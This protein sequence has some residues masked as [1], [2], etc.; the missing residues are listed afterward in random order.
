MKINPYIFR[1]YDLRGEIN[2]DLNPKIAEH[3]GR[4]FG[5]MLKRQGIKKA[6]IGRDSR[7]TSLEYSESIIK[8]L[9]FVGINTIDIGMELIGTFYW[10]QYFLNCQGGVFVSASHN[11]AQYNGFK[12][13]NGFSETLISKEMKIL[14]QMAEND[15]FEKSLILGK[16]EKISIRENYFNDLVKKISFNKKFKVLID[17]GNSTAGDIVPD[18]LRKLN[19]EVFEQNCKLDSSFPL[20]VPDPTEK[21]VMER[22]KKGVLENQ[23][24][25]GFIYDCDGDRIGVVDNKGNIIWNDILLAIFAVSVLKKHPG[26]TIMYNALCSQIVEET[27]LK[28]KGKPFMWRTGH[29][30]LKNKNKEIKAA[31]IGE[32]SGHFFFSADFYNH[33][34]GI[35]S[36][37]SLLQYISQSKEPLSQI[38]NSFIKYISSPEIKIGCP[39][40]LKI[41]VIEKIGKK[42][43]AGF[44]DAKIIDDERVGDGIRV[45][46]DDFMFI[47]RYSQ[48]GPYLTV[49]FEAQKQDK[50]DY[51]KKYINKLLHSFGE[52]DWSFGVNI[53]SLE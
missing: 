43:K 28:R 53:E 45:S 42:I 18:L 37:L 8:G 14:R 52:I 29:S 36:T 11:P 5:A 47:I 3:L 13:A 35:Y 2:K 16:N 32:L 6:V 44:S 46:K 12:F 31:F 40:E 17:A 27:I 15:D 49:K 21:I 30:F 7:Q 9:N 34:D 4:V 20:G 24:D 39:D 51:L 10:A 1:G 26:S 38:F 25:I 33:D 22:V 19:C 41:S 50:Y 48:N 23:C